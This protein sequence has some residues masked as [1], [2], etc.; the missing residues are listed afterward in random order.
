MKRLHQRK[1]PAQWKA[2]AILQAL[3]RANDQFDGVRFIPMQHHHSVAVFAGSSGEDYGEFVDAVCEVAVKQ[4]EKYG[5]PI[6]GEAEYAEGEFEHTRVWVIDLLSTCRTGCDVDL[7]FLVE[8]I[9]KQINIRKLAAKHGADAGAC[10]IIDE[11]AGLRSDVDDF[12]DLLI[13]LCGEEASDWYEDD[14]DEEVAPE[15]NEANAEGAK[16]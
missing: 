9:N 11:E 6:I 12:D 14:D 8:K 1:T 10:V 13:K 7:S 2:F 16:S 15:V 4:F 5:V 3:L